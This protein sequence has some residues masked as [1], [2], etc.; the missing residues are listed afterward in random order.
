MQAYAKE[1][2]HVI[3]M[4][5]DKKEETQEKHFP[6]GIYDYWGGY[7]AKKANKRAMPKMLIEYFRNGIFE[8]QKTGEKSIQIE[9]IC[10]GLRRLVNIAKSCNYIP[11]TGNILNSFMKLLC[12]EQKSCFKKLLMELASYS[13]CVSHDEWKEMVKIMVKILVY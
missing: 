6:K 9:W 7:E 5:H 1:G 10:K 8:F 11:V 13:A 4:V 12:D 3:G 2:I